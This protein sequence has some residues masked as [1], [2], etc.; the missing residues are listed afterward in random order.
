MWH[1]G[2]VWENL[3]ASNV[4]EPGVSGWRDPLNEWP[5]WVQP[6]GAHDA[7]QVGAK[8]THAGNRWISTAANNVWAPGVFGWTQQP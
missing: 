4:W 3:T 2:Q 5:A 1:A 7:Y 8:V 6:A